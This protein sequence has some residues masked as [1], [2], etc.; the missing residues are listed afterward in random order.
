MF[1]GYAGQ[2]LE[3]SCAYHNI[4]QHDAYVSDAPYPLRLRGVLIHPGSRKLGSMKA[5]MHLPCFP[6][7]PAPGEDEGSKSVL[8]IPCT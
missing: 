1:G 3:A 6:Q 4:V 7:A 2:E 8:N 5:S